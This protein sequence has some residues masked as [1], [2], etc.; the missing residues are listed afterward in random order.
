MRRK[1][2]WHGEEIRKEV[3]GGRKWARSKSSLGRSARAKE[4]N[5][6]RQGEKR[7][8]LLNKTCSPT[9]GGKGLMI[10]QF[11]TRRGSPRKEVD[12]KLRARKKKTRAEAILG[13]LSRGNCIVSLK[14]GTGEF[15]QF[16]RTDINAIGRKKR[17]QKSKGICRKEEIL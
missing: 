10:P 14:K 13:E 16:A 11:L 17:R 4:A 12:D 1:G 6:K 2:F 15:G 7:F 3:D 5:Q 8:D 9:G